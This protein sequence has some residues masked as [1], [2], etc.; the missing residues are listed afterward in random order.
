MSISCP[1][2]PALVVDSRLIPFET[3]DDFTFWGSPCRSAVASANRPAPV[4]RS[5]SPM[6]TFRSEITL[7][8]P[9]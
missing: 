5:A 2:R 1:A 7:I 4:R 3:S 9:L 8:V 6:R